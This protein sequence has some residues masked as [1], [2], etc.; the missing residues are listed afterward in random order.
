MILK[1][2]I[3]RMIRGGFLEVFI[4]KLMKNIEKSSPESLGIPKN[5]QRWAGSAGIAAQVA[6]VGPMG[7][8]WRS[9]GGPGGIRIANEGLQP[10]K[11]RPGQAPLRAFLNI[12]LLYYY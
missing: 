10:G 7:A 9:N 8:Q 5:Q 2:L 11:G 4:T 1:K 6:N 12:L 3:C